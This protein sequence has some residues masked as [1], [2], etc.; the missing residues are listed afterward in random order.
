MDPY[1]SLN[2]ETYLFVVD[3]SISLPIMACHFGIRTVALQMNYIQLRIFKCLA[4]FEMS[5]AE[6]YIFMYKHL[7]ITLM[8]YPVLLNLNYLVTRNIKPRRYFHYNDIY[9]VR[10]VEYH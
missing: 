2:S 1:I 8:Y 10:V 7:Q 4:G 5:G 3:F 6:N 9:H